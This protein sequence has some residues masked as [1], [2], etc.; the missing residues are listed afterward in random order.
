MLNGA[1]A[2]VWKG[3]KVWGL[4]GGDWSIARTV[5]SPRL[6]TQ[7]AQLLQLDLSLGREAAFSRGSS[8][9]AQGTQLAG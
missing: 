1:R 8:V 2:S 6:E 7:A 4:G 5:T 3:E 9:F